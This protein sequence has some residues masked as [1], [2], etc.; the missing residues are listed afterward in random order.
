[1]LAKYSNFSLYPQLTSFGFYVTEADP[2][3][4]GTTPLQS[5]TSAFF[6]K[7]LLAVFTQRLVSLMG[8]PN[9]INLTPS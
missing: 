1:M 7:D 9:F 5:R 6:L 4:L 2:E 8:T 3:V